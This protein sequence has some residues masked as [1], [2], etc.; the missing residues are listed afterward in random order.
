VQQ[1]HCCNTNPLPQPISQLQPNHQLHP[2]ISNH[3]QIHT[4]MAATPGL[5][6][7]QS[8]SANMC[9]SCWWSAKTVEH[10]LNCPPAD[11]KNIWHDLH[12]SFYKLIQNI[13]S[14]S[15]IT[16]FS[17][18]NYLCDN[19]SQQEK[20]IAPCP[21]CI[22][23]QTGWTR[24]YHKLIHFLMY[25]LADKGIF[26]VDTVKT[27]LLLLM[28]CQSSDTLLYN[29]YTIHDKM[30][31]I[32]KSES[33]REYWVN[34]GVFN[35]LL[36]LSLPGAQQQQCYSFFHVCKLHDMCMSRFPAKLC[37]LDFLFWFCK[38]ST[39]T[40]SILLT[41]KCSSQVKKAYIVLNCI[42]LLDTNIN[43]FVL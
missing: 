43:I 39:G 40:L 11:R 5:I 1:V 41:V 14:L 7:V 38:D 21:L 33:T 24:E 18:L 9:L 42:G 3:Q 8:N 22:W 23:V 34:K 2:Y 29:G 13:M 28:Q 30:V 37:H 15:T 20:N 12:D 16:I 27:H 10:F 26:A 17:C 4:Q 6:H 25:Y 32:K 31:L 36:L 35:V 19:L